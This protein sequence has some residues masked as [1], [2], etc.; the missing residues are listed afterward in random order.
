MIFF[1]INFVVETIDLIIRL[2]R[3]ID[4]FEFSYLILFLHD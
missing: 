2:R 1:K 4:E 3:K